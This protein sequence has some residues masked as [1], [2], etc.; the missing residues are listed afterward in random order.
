MSQ[1][2]LSGSAAAI[3]VTKSQRPRSITS[4]MIAAAAR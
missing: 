4:S 2:I 1:M 3:S